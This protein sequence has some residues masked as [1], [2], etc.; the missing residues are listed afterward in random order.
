[1]TSTTEDPPA[2]NETIAP[3]DV[4]RHDDIPQQWEVSASTGTFDDPLLVCLSTLAG[5]LDRP[6]SVETLK[7]GLPVDAS[8]MAPELCVR[9]AERAGLQAR[10]TRRAKISKIASL[11][12]PCILL[13]KDRGAC[14]LLELPS[15]TE[16]HIITPES[17]GTTTV[18]LNDLQESYTGYALFAKTTAHFDERT[19][20][21]TLI[22]TKRWFW[23]TLFRFLPI[24]RHVLLASF[25]INMLAIATP[26][27]TMNVYDRVVPNNALET[28]KVLAIGIVIVFAFDFVLKNLRSYFV[29]VAGKSADIIIASK[30][31]Q[32]VMGMRFDQRPA[33]SGSLA[34]NLREFE[35]LRDFFSSSTLIV[36]VDLPFIFIFI[37]VIWTIGGPIATVPLAMAPLVIIVGLITQ[38][39]LGHVVSKTY[40]ESSQKHSL[41]IEAINGLEAIKAAGAEGQIQRQWEKLVSLTAASSGKARMI[42][43]L[44]TSFAQ[45]ATQL[46]T[47]GVVIFGVFEIADG[48]MTIGAL[49]ACTIL[50]GRAMSPLGAVAAM[51]TKYQQSRVALKGLDE[52]MKTPVERPTSKAFIHRPDIDGSVEIRNVTFHYPNS[53]SNALEQVTLKVKAGERVGIIGR[54]GSGKSTIGRLLIGLYEPNDGALMI[55]GSDI[56][57][58]DPAELRRNIGYV[59]QDNYLFF[60]SVRDNIIFGAQHVDDRTILRAAEVAGVTDFLARSPL[61]FDL[62]VGERG[63]G[64]SGGQ[65]QAVA[66]ARALL[67]DPPVLVLDEPTSSM[68]NSSETTFKNRLEA[69]LGERTLILIT[70]RGSMLSLVD[71]LVIVDA[72]RVVADGP[73]EDVMDALR[74]GQ[75]RGAQ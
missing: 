35:S 72:G 58:L 42:S 59:S 67:L 40:R 10:I 62:P 2:G 57:Q 63:M 28:L 55:G 13:L 27:F 4:L 23:G 15:Q 49:I 20:D 74:K 60:G 31:L 52:L 41:L 37:F 38:F 46:T 32:Q 1:V 47:V 43:T 16:A 5:I 56:R 12:L 71:R 14:V 6:T 50:V 66:V 36:I 25:M 26:L 29:D 73:K 3:A 64:L 24:Y 17:G 75:V 30:L 54:I 11:T 61:G 21:L 8:G 45:T 39:P 69:T 65:R 33:S 68:D 9:A 44:S 18:Q 22:D 34:N 19:A 53:Q 51:L 7:A 70:H 48:N